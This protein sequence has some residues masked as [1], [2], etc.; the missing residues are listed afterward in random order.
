MS[1][2]PQVKGTNHLEG[3]S[4]FGSVLHQAGRFTILL[5]NTLE[6]LGRHPPQSPHSQLHKYCIKE[7]P[8]ED[9]RSKLGKI[10]TYLILKE[11]AGWGA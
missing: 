11:S 10:F 4:I 3:L 5:Q 9:Q 7:W 6:S 1:V 2:Y 8:R